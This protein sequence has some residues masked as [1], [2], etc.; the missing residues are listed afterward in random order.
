[1]D[2]NDVS[3]TSHQ[4]KVPVFNLYRDPKTKRVLSRYQILLKWYRNK[5]GHTLNQVRKTLY[6]MSNQEQLEVMHKAVQE[7]GLVPFESPVIEHGYKQITFLGKL[8]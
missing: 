1:M 7:F 8:K 3:I 2:N 5:H 6:T 4:D